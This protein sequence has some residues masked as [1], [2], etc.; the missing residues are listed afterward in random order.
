MA[1]QYPR[2]TARYGKAQPAFPKEVRNPDAPASEK[3]KVYL[4]SLAENHEIGMPI[5]AFMAMYAA[6][7]EAEV[8]T[9]GFVSEL[10]DEYKAY[11]KRTD[12]AEVMA[13]VERANAALD[14]LAQTRTKAT[15]ET[16]PPGYYVTGSGP[17]KEFWV[18]V[19]NQAKTGTYAKLQIDVHGGDD[20]CITVQP[21]SLEAMEMSPPYPIK[22]EA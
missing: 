4:R 6:W 15:A 19:E 17:N 14:G 22:E 2:V 18:V 20:S 5:K 7:D 9:A 8:L 16:V 11:P 3:A 12:M 10:I 13:Y 21:D 1:K